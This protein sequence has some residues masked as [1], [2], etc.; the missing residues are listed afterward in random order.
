[1]TQ[2]VSLVRQNR[3]RGTE[4]GDVDGAPLFTFDA[5]LD[6]NTTS[7]AQV[8]TNPT[9]RGSPIADHVRQ[10]LISLELV[11]IVTATPLA[12]AGWATRDLDQYAA[13][14]AIKQAGEFLTVVAGG[15]TYRNMVIN[16]L[17]AKRSTGDGRSVEVTLSLIEVR[18]VEGRTVTLPPRRLLRALTDRIGEKS[19]A[20]AG[21]TSS[22]TP[23]QQNASSSQANR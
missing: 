12:E 2:P 11:G 22:L 8:T 1:M 18:V 4:I 6:S 19:D 3:Q 15:E 10:G 9:E 5:T 21:N 16:R 13:L 14:L 20:G 17:A 7:E 23:A